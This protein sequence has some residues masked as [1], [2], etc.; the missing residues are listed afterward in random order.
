MIEIITLM[1]D[2]E[3]SVGCSAEHGL[4]LYI[5]TDS[6]T[7]LFDS[8]A[9]PL[10]WENAAKVRADIGEVEALVLS[11]GHNDHGGGIKSFIRLNDRAKLYI[12]S[13][14][15]EPHYSLSGG[16]HFIGIAPELMLNERTVVTGEYL[17]INEELSVF[18]AVDGRKLH[19]SSN[20]NL[21]VMRGHSLEPD[22]FSHEQNAVIEADG[23]RILIAG[24]AHCGIVNILERFTALYGGMPDIIIGGFHMMKNSDYTEDERALI[25]AT[26]RILDKSG[27]VCYTG[28]CTGIAAYEIMKPVMGEKMHYIHSGDRLL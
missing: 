21:Q 16:A 10:T 1:E 23:K 19:P 28:H 17:K 27:A 18:S 5:R 8:G 12:R 4:S 9:S 22:D 14:A 7:C 26:A 3:G 15:D 2:T 6:H 11:H 25:E 20:R 24:C 13:G